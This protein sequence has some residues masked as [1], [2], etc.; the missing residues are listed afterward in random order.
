ME[1][2][3]S[4]IFLGIKFESKELT[5]AYDACSYYAET[6]CSSDTSESIGKGVALNTDSTINI[7]P[8]TLSK[9]PSENMAAL[10][11]R[12]AYAQVI[13]NINDWRVNA[14]FRYDKN[15]LYG[16]SVNPRASA[17]YY[18]SNKSTV[19]LLYGTAFQEPAPIQ[20]WG[21]WSGR[22][23]NPNLKPEKAEN[24]ELIYMY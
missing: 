2:L 10:I 6:F 24:L 7:Q 5:K 8:N 21:G 4:I 22:A 19:K 20:L 15:S 18:L 1:K 9:M 12:G 23:A 17:I 16:S 11:D 3:C 13:W 14:G